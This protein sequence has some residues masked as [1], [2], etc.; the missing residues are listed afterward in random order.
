MLLQLVFQRGGA[1]A[2]I[3]PMAKLACTAAVLPAAAALS[4]LRVL[5]M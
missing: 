3:A 5:L 4:S 1:L 2:E